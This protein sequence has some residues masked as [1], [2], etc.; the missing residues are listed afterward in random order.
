MALL[1]EKDTICALSTANGVGA[2]AVIRVSGEDA[3]K[4]TSAIFSKD[5]TKVDSHSVHFGTI[6][7]AEQKV[8]DEVLV[9]VL[10]EGKSFTGENTTEIACHGSSYIKQQILNLLFKAGCRMANPGEF[11]M[12]AYFNGRMDLSQA[13]AI[14]DLISADSKK[15]HEIAMNQ[16]RGGYSDK[17]AHL[18]QRLM[19]FA[20]L[21]ELELDFSEEDVE[22]ASRTELN[23]L[24]VELK[25]KLTLLT[26]SFAYG[27]AIKHGISTVIAG[28][29]NAG[30]STLLNALLNEERAIVSSIPGTT[31]DTIE[32]R[33]TIDGILYNFIDTAGIR[34]ATDEIEKIGV[35]RA[36][37]EVNKSNILLY[38]FD[39]KELDKETVEN[40]L[41][42][43]EREGLSIVLLANKTEE[44]D[45]S[46][47]SSYSEKYPIIPISAKK[48]QGLEE[49]KLELAKSAEALSTESDT[50][51]I[52][53]RH[54]EAFYNA[55]A[56]MNQ[57]ENA[58]AM[59]ISGDLLAMDIR[60]AIRHLSSI[61]GEITTDD[62]LGNIF[63]NFCIGK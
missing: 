3:L 21:I 46:K 20:S 27:N 19:D 43:L 38:V 13:E 37:S 41:K 42:R 39:A 10:K 44:M 6:R 53:A 22:F 62:L 34:E 17:I 31:R 12:R 40:D 14:A 49:L 58:L 28:R 9:T 7:D 25:E 32:E 8:I 1:I 30:K 54:Y 50:I 26:E 52:N 45:T 55:L 18:R 11:T 63:A 24:V 29:P 36:M 56:D 48:H 16:M 47:L 61:T 2:I 15:G 60:S 59:Q 51:V 4:I 23:E 33:L 5:L 57:V 35:E